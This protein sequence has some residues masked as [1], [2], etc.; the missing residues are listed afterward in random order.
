MYSI[1]TIYI[2]VHTYLLN[3]KFSKTRK[4]CPTLEVEPGKI[5][6]LRE[7]EL[8]LGYNLSVNYFINS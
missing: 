4:K 5:F 3:Y 1:N 8:S 6:A 7:R 2:H